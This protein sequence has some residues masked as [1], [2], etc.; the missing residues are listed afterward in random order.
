MKK[1]LTLI[2]RDLADNKGAL[3]ITPFAI[4]SFVFLLIL[5]SIL[6]G[7]FQFETDKGFS[8]G[9]TN[10]P[11]SEVSIDGEKYKIYKENGVLMRDD[12]IKKEPFV[13]SIDSKKREAISSV[14]VFGTAVGTML[15]VGVA[16]IA[17]LFVLSGA[18]YDERKERN[19]MFWKSLPISDLQTVLAKAFS[20][21]GGG[22][23]AALLAAFTLHIALMALLIISGHA[24]G[25][26]LPSGD[27]LDYS[28]VFSSTFMF[29]GTMVLVI[30]GYILWALPVY[31][32]FLAASAFAPK[33]PFFWAI[34]P[35]G[36]L[37]LIAKI[38]FNG[39]LDAS[40]IPM[41][42]LVGLPVLKGF[43]QAVEDFD[44]AHGM[45]DSLKAFNLEPIYSTFKEPQ[46]WIG[47]L[48]A[49]I[50]LYAAS[51]IRRRK[52]L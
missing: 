13:G 11:Q 27:V 45:V 49:G 9:M 22:L 10:T 37:P 41:Q 23:G 25:V 19:I 15:P 35:I 51:E 36:L 8:M 2:K 1:F 12:G 21:I 52:A 46:L 5:I 26:R 7:K 30:C 32:W 6:M 34:L 47:V 4:V 38:F 17:I 28:I 33:A 50:L 31:A 48:V 42:H 16:M 3:I 44:D 29:W 20:T 24:M 39:G 18:L 43:S 14:F 40:F